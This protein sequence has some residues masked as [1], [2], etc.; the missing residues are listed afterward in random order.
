MSACDD[1]P[2]NNSLFRNLQPIVGIFNQK[3]HLQTLNWTLFP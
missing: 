1:S 2:L 3:G